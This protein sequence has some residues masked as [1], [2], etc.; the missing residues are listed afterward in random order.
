MC[1]DDVHTLPFLARGFNENYK[2]VN[3]IEYKDNQHL[4]EILTQTHDSYFKNITAM[5]AKKSSFLS[6]CKTHETQGG[7]VHNG[8]L[9]HPYPPSRRIKIVKPVSQ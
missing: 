8:G 2:N 6:D 5:P 4:L 7:R 1:S 9:S 3:F